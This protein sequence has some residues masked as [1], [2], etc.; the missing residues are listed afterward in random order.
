[1]EDGSKK[2]VELYNKANSNKNRIVLLNDNGRD[3]SAAEMTVLACLA[4]VAREAEFSKMPNL[5]KEVNYDKVI[6]TL[7]LSSLDGKVNGLKKQNEYSEI[8]D[9]YKNL[10]PG[11]TY[12][13]NIVYK[14]MVDNFAPFLDP[15]YKEEVFVFEN[16]KLQELIRKGHIYWG[17]NK[18]RL[19]SILEH[20]YGCLVLAIGLE[21]EYSYSIDFNK[22]FK[23]LL[24]HETGEISIGDLTEWDISEKE[25]KK[26]ERKSVIN[27]LSK[28]QGG[29]SLIELFDEFNSK[30]TL[31]SE[32]ANL[33]DKIEYDMQVKVYED[34]GAY[35]FSNYPR[36]VVTESERVKN[37]I[38]SGASGVFDVHYQYDKN[39]Y[40][41]FPCMRRILEET[42]NYDFTKSEEE[43]KSSLRSITPKLIKNC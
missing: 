19:E 3:F 10:E 2:I 42:R 39:R 41:K 12:G 37:I 24:I 35:D 15:V 23:M 25:K 9:S 40:Q 21:S 11:P 28:L 29:E 43:T 30:S 16:L 14:G 4:V 7:I 31:V 26:I 38:D 33:I 1:M 20:I 5:P 36:N 13:A 6:K 22:L 32:Y 8:I 34:N 17:A 18:E 27:I